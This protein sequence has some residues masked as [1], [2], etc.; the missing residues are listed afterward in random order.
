MVINFVR[1]PSRH[2]LSF[3]DDVSEGGFMNYVTHIKANEHLSAKRRLELLLNCCGA[4]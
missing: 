2:S 1:V 4:D 3:P